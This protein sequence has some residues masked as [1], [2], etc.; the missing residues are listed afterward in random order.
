M[1][2]HLGVILR[3]RHC[4]TRNTEPD[5]RRPTLHHQ[6]PQGPQARTLLTRMFQGTD[7][8]R[9]AIRRMLRL[10]R[11]TRRRQLCLLRVGTPPVMVDILLRRLPGMVAILL[12]RI[13]HMRRLMRVM[14]VVERRGRWGCTTNFPFFSLYCDFRLSRFVSSLIS[15]SFHYSHFFFRNCILKAYIDLIALSLVARI[16]TYIICKLHPCIRTYI[17]F[18]PRISSISLGALFCCSVQDHIHQNIRVLDT[19]SLIP[20]SLMTTFFSPFDS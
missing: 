13:Q 4:R 15:I 11:I 5:T 12:G 9:G 1:D 20:S 19:H 7:T 18:I 6:Q 16:T 10:S 3:H 17:Q 8:L 2:T 14:A